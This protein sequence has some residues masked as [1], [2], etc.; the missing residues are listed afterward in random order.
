MTDSIGNTVTMNVT[1]ANNM[2]KTTG[3]TS[4]CSFCTG[5]QGSNMKYNANGFVS[6]VTDYKNNI[7]TYNWD[8]NR[9]LLLST[10]EAKNT[11]QERTTAYTWDNTWRLPKTITEPVYGGSKVTTFNY[12]SNGN[13]LDKIISAPSGGFGSSS[14]TWI[15]TYDGLGQLTELKTSRYDDVG[16]KYNFDYDNGRLSKI[17]NALGQQ[18]IFSNFSNYGKAQIV[19]LSNGTRLVLEYNTL[20]N[21]TKST[22]QNSSHS[23]NIVTQITY[24][25]A[26][27]VEKIIDPE[28]HYQKIIYDDA[29]RVSSIEEYTSGNVLLGKT[30]YT[31]DNMSNVTKVQIFD[32]ANNEIRLKTAQYDSKN[33]LWK[34]IGAINQSSTLTYDLNSNLQQITDSN[35]KNIVF[36]YDALDRLTSQTN[37]DNGVINYTYNPDDSLATVQDPKGLTTSYGYN[38]FGEIISITSPDTGLTQYVRDNGGNIIQK[39]DAKNQIFT[40]SYDSLNRLSSVGY[41]DTSRNV[42]L[43]YDCDL[44]STGKLCSVTDGTDL[45]IILMIDLG[46]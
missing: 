42:S 21:L 10:T 5:L 2:Y 1:K 45:P 33:R 19:D 7:T 3:F 15:Y 29:Q 12:D 27:Q 43:T 39:T 36:S 17:T 22:K 37:Q 30:V 11:T 18:T 23:E 4:F 24:D 31:L 28:G 41:Q 20:G 8:M 38:G 46:D 13:L 16:E 25:L 26:Q 6:Q 40:Y 44:T 9:N 32:S 35:N 34:D 14:R